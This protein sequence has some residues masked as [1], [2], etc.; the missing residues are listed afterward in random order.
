MGR[1]EHV[2]DQLDAYAGEVK[3]LMKDFGKTPFNGPLNKDETAS[4]FLIAAI[5]M[6][7]DAV[8]DVEKRLGEI[9]DSLNGI[10]STLYETE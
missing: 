9:E 10:A 1:I 5:D 3:C 6:L 2:S 7:A 8:W 4:I